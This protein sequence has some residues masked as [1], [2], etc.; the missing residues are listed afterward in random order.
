MK[1][2]LVLAA[3]IGDFVWRSGGTLAKYA[4]AGAQIKLIVLSYGLRGESNEYWKQEGATVEAGKAIRHAEGAAAAKILGISDLEVLDFDDYPLEI[5][6]ERMLQLAEKIRRFAPD[7]I[8]THDRERDIYN[9]DHTL[10]GE[11]IQHICS[12][13]CAK[14]INLSNT[15]VIKR[16]AIYGFEPHVSEICHFMP[17]VYVDITGVME[18]KKQAMEAYATQKQMYAA[19]INRCRLRGLQTGISGCEYAEAF[20]YRSPVTHQPLLID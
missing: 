19:Y 15:P 4:E 12:I 16:P 6:R 10:V 5:D 11:K 1:R 13:A 9:A 8:L 14:G 3:H 20:S 17:Q 7:I 18:K 2:I